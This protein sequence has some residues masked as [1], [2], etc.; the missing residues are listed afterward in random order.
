MAKVT[1]TIYAL[2]FIALLFMPH[3]SR[4]VGVVSQAYM[5]SIAML[6]I[7]GLAYL[8]YHLH[9]NELYKR[10][11][12][13]RTLEEHLDTSEKRLIESFQYIG[14]MNRKLPLLKNLSSDLLGRHQLTKKGK[15]SI[16]DALLSTAVVSIARVHSG[17]FRFVEVATGRTRKEF[18]LALEDAIGAVRK[19]G[20]RELLACRTVTGAFKS[21]NGYYIVPASDQTASVQNFLIVAQAK[22][23][24][25]VEYPTLQAITDQAQLFYK[26]LF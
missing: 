8:T 9:N 14:S 15:K 4:H 2:L 20:N 17:M 11:E 24:T 16:F 21:I 1:N 10:E 13:V 6:A 18:T 7:F 26:Y 23:E 12:R 5:E 3:L 22:T 25:E 19:I